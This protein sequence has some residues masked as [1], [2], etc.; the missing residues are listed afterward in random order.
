MNNQQTGGMCKC[1]HH[2]MKGWLVIA[3]GLAYLLGIYNVLTS[4]AVSTI[5]AIVIIAAGAG[6]LCKCC[7]M[8]GMCDKTKM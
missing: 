7:N 2:K 1:P 8:H 6:M 4:I 3:F 5:W